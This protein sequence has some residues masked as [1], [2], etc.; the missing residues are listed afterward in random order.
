[1]RSAASRSPLKLLGQLGAIV[2]VLLLAYWFIQMRSL[3]NDV[4]PRRECENA[5]REARTLSETLAVD[6]RQP[7]IPRRDRSAIAMTCGSL[8]RANRLTR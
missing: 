4:L 1:M 5:Y 3:R 2:L 7:V 8:R 6:G